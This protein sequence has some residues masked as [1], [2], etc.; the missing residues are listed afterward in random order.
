VILY[1]AKCLSREILSKSSFSKR[2]DC[3][4]LPH[5]KRKVHDSFF[6]NKTPLLYSFCDN[7]KE[8]RKTVLGKQYKEME[9]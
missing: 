7:N 4:H 2:I 6:T 1:F 8:E 5:K 3:S 9:K